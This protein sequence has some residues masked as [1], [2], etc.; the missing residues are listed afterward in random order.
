LSRLLIKIVDAEPGGYADVIYDES[1]C[2]FELSRFVWKALRRL[3]PH[4]GF[5]ATLNKTIGIRCGKCSSF[6]VSC[7]DLFY[8]IVPEPQTVLGLRW[9]QGKLADFAYDLL[10]EEVWRLLNIMTEEKITT[11]EEWANFQ[12]NSMPEK[13]ILYTLS[14]ELIFPEEGCPLGLV[15]DEVY[16][17]LSAACVS[18]ERHIC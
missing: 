7:R 9:P 16:F 14:G 1:G 17:K 6:T 8:A 12:N 5:F 13:K 11:M 2:V 4:T 15:F 18:C 3:E 10:S